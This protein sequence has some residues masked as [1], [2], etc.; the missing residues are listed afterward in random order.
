M[1]REVAAAGRR[2]RSPVA[3]IRPWRSSSSFGAG[4]AST[5][6]TPGSLVSSPSLEAS[7]LARSVAYGPKLVAGPSLVP[8][9]L[10]RRARLRAVVAGQRLDRHAH[11]ARRA[12]LRGELVGGGEREG[13]AHLLGARDVVAQRAARG[14]LGE[15]ELGV[16]GHRLTTRTPV[17]RSR[18]IQ[19][20][21]GGPMNW[22][23][24][25][26]G[27]RPSGTPLRSPRRCVVR[28]LLGGVD[29]AALEPDAVH[30]V[31]AHGA[32]RD[33]RLGVARRGLDE[34]E[35]LVAGDRAHAG[36]RSMRPRSRRRAARR[37]PPTADR[38]CVRRSC[39]RPRLRPPCDEREQEAERHDRGHDA[40]SGPGEGPV[41]RHHFPCL[42][43][44]LSS[45]LTP[46]RLTDGPS[47]GRMADA[48]LAGRRNRAA[49]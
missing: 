31:A 42:S 3:R 35:A 16:L 41:F 28:R 8:I 29:G 45:E 43:A 44:D 1:G 39:G 13:A 19:S 46:Q 6:T 25:S 38:H 18:A 23:T 32:G 21:F 22:T 24:T 2:P 36:A 34:Q 9:A 33:E 12:I 27:L 10:G 20:S 30:V 47:G 7:T 48:R 37:R 17:A 4:S 5:A 11:A 49:A 26:S 40:A 14:A 15:H